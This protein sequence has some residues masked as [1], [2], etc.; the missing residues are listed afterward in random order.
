MRSPVISDFPCCA[1]S[2]SP[3][4]CAAAVL[5]LLLTLF[6]AFCAGAQTPPDGTAATAKPDANKPDA[7][8]LT[9]PVE[10]APEAS[11]T[12]AV[13]DPF[14]TATAPGTATPSSA[15]ATGVEVRNLQILSIRSD[16]A[17]EQA[18][19]LTSA[20]KLSVQRAPGWQ[21]PP[22]DF[23]LEVLVA[24]LD[25]T[26]P[27]NAGCLAEIA[28]RTKSNHFVYG[29]LYRIGKGVRADLHVWQAGEQ[30]SL[31]FDYSDNLVEP[32]DDALFNLARLA[33]ATL[34]G[35][36]A[37][38]VA[39]AVDMDPTTLRWNGR[40][41]GVI[42]GGKGSLVLP[43][44][45]H[46]LVAEALGHRDEKVTVTVVEGETTT[47]SIRFVPPPPVEEPALVVVA[48]E[49]SGGISTRTALGYTGIGLGT[50]LIVGGVFAAVDVQS[51]SDD[52]ELASYRAAL[53][54]SQ[55]ACV[56]A[57]A[58]KVLPGAPAPGGV[59]ELCDSADTLTALQYVFFGL[60]AA[61]VG[62]GA[63]FL[64]SA[65]D[66]EESAAGRPQLRARVGHDSAKVD[67]TLA[68]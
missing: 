64:I 16:D 32:A 54:R 15:A 14:G 11:K 58:G 41:V 38:T 50:A 18:D 23:S 2:V 55:D 39:V 28:N 10:S 53:A 47:L 61:A 52:A 29:S 30:T 68:F 21:V 8:A 49:A 42:T 56:E 34:L 57:R 45:E 37:G 24:A 36:D 31:Q 12:P 7:G 20:L 35:L 46:A 13:V 66:S 62:T 63:Y 44:G 19:A 65:D 51:K 43:T 40:P 26:D 1:G 4:R 48:D 59:A 3:F 22:G 6:V 67:L 60:G 33:L 5:T 9:K 27:P 17:F 25:C